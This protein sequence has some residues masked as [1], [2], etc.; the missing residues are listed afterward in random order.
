M[1]RTGNCYDNAVMQSFFAM[2]K[3]ECVDQRYATRQEARACVFDYIEGW[4]NR[5]RRHSA[6]A[7]LSP[8]AYERRYA[9][10]KLTVYEMQ[11]S[12]HS[13][14]MRRSRDI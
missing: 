4:Y 8:E 10:D 11:V 7:Y 6:L 9:R 12:S 3:T 14:F 5:R 1:S 13:G 2:L